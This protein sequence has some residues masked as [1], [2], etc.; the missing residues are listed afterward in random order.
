MRARLFLVAIAS[1]TVVANLWLGVAWLVAL[2]AGVAVLVVGEVAG[3]LLSSQR[4]VVSSSDVRTPLAAVARA[5]GH[6]LSPRELEVAVLIAKGLKSKEVGARLLIE[7]G[8]VDK[9]IEHIYDKL[10]FDSRPQL[11]IWLMERGLLAKSESDEVNT[12]SYK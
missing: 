5:D 10:G 12:N 11:A 6:P 1:I 9:H 3:R 4:L 7:R 8:T 2:G